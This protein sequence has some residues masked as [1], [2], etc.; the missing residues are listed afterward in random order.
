MKK[1][2]C[3]FF[4]I[5]FIAIGLFAINGGISPQAIAG[6]G[7]VHAGH[8]HARHDHAG[9]DHADKK[10]LTAQ[11][12][13]G[14]EDL[15]AEDEHAED[16]HTE[17]AQKNHDHKPSDQHA[18]HGHGESGCSSDEICPEH[19][20]PE[21]IDALCLA[22]HIG[23]LT[24]GQ[25]M[26][27]RLAAKDVAEK[28]G[29]R[30]SEPTRIMMAEGKRIPGHAVFDREQLA[31]MTSLASGVVQKV[32]VQP[33]AKV[34]KGDLLVEIAIPE[35]AGLKAD[36]I[37]A[38]ARRVQAKATYQREKDLLE[39]GISSRQEFQLAEAEYLASQ[40]AT[41][42]YRHQLLNFGLSEADLNRLAQ[43][44]QVGANVFLRAP[45]AGL[46]IE[47][48]TTTGEAVNTGT[49][50]VKLANIDSLWIELD[51][52]E[53]MIYQAETGVKVQAQFDGLPGMVFQG[54][55]F[56]VG[57][58]L[59]ERSRTLKALAEVSNP[60]HRLKV[61]MFGSVKILSSE[62]M[63]RL[64]IPEEAVQNIDGQTYLF[65]QEEPD[66][67]ELRRVTTG[68]DQDGLVVVAAG[69][70]PHDRVVSGQGF[71]LKSEVLK[72]RLGAS[73]ADH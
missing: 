63:A 50:L 46:V 16:D 18:G 38:Q 62:T 44:Q 59:D 7:G 27:V 19:N 12:E 73:C 45:F 13:K 24:P 33:G 43:S 57:A 51:I 72:A 10:G 58:E 5:A 2:F 29:V 4:F 30:T 42:R 8:D 11:D 26:K 32:Y 25:G 64:A 3:L 6:D 71:A 66:L 49:P 20:V 47:L 31:H 69:L 22:D 61:G 60:G 56:Q 17:H 35:V 41:E 34:S 65:I 68:A 21:N 54:E 37:A 39:R 9:H 1:L 52:P 70:Q 67:Y 48:Q 23:E 28:A 15:F 14:L 36:F 55:L 40:S 53:S